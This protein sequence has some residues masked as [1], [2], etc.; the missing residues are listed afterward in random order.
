MSLGLQFQLQELEQA[1]SSRSP[2]K[3]RLRQAM[4]V[5]AL[6]DISWLIPEAPRLLNRLGIQVDLSALHPFM[7][8]LP[9]VG[10]R[11]QSP[12]QCTDHAGGAGDMHGA[13][14]TADSAVYCNHC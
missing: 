9:K 10:G 8:Q 6:S 2:N 14:P 7:V 4:G 12:K 3:D 1:L 11:I 13:Q 5:T